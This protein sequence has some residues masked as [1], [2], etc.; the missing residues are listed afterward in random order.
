MLLQAG[1][2]EA[3]DSQKAELFSAPADGTHSIV[4]NDNIIMVFSLDTKDSSSEPFDQLA[5]SE[6]STGKN[7]S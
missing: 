3:D 1:K 7:C 5:S 2:G 6:Q 4:T